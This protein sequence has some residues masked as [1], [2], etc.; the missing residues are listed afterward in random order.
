MTRYALDLPLDLKKDAEM[1][2]RQQG[3]SLNKFIMWAVAEKVVQMRDELDDP[4]FPL[5][6]YY[7]GASGHPTPVLRGTRIR[8]QTMAVAVHKHKEKPED[9]ARDYELDIAQVREALGFYDAHKWEIDQNI[10]FENNLEK[11]HK[12]E[13]AMSK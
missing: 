5:I 13:M 3:I 11:Q 10:D 8:V 9:L 7:R 1:I 6:T 4:K 2:A 12:R